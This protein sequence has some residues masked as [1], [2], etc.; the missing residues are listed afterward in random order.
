MGSFSQNLLGKTLPGRTNILTLF[1][2]CAVCSARMKV[3]IL[4][5]VAIVSTSQGADKS[6]ICGY[7][8]I[9]EVIS[10]TKRITFDT[11]HDEI[12][13]IG[14]VLTKENG[15]YTA[16]KAGVFHVE[17]SIQNGWTHPGAIMKIFLKAPRYQANHEHELLYQ[18]NGYANLKF[19]T[20]MSGS[21]YMSLEEGDQVFMDFE[22]VSSK[23]VLFRTKFCI[24]F[25]ADKPEDK[26]ATVIFF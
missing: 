26:F 22:C 20:S 2:S 21:R 5:I 23:C 18:N 19:G 8:A 17:T 1:N 16:G 25:Y 7:S 15:V 10:G 13:E 9:Q 4:L 24:S 11:V 6:A 3:C 12:N 14:S